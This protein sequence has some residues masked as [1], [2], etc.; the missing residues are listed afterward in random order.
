MD[1]KKTKVI[2]ITLGI[3]IPVVYTIIYIPP[4]VTI[5]Q[6]IAAIIIFLVVIYIAIQAMKYYKIL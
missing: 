5:G 6:V 4:E 2:R 3:L 1:E